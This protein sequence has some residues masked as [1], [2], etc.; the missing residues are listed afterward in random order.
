[1]HVRRPLLLF[2]RLTIVFCVMDSIAVSQV[3]F[4]VSGTCFLLTEL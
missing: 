1:M 4:S 2:G 3:S